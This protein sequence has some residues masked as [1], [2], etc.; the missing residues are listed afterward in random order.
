MMRACSAAL[1]DVCSVWCDVVGGRGVQTT[2]GAS[3][4]AMHPPQF[5]HTDTIPSRPLLLNSRTDAPGFMDF[6]QLGRFWWSVFRLVTLDS[7]PTSTLALNMLKAARL[8]PAAA[9]SFL[10]SSRRLV[11]LHVP[12]LR[13]KRRG[14]L[15]NPMPTSASSLSHRMSTTGRPL[16]F[17][18]CSCPGAPPDTS[19]NDTVESWLQKASCMPEGAHF[20]LCTHPLEGYSASSSPNGSRLPKGV[21][22]GR[23]STPLMK[24]EN[25]RALKSLL[26]VASRMLLGCQSTLRTVDLC[27]LMCLD[28]HQ[29]LSTSK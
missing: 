10:A 8:A 25:T 13:E 14:L 17:T 29:S 21:S 28:T 22:P 2:G 20:T 6:R 3:S 12:P 1:H 16:N 4:R 19:T 18:L 7:A 5:F 15:S 9:A 24:P 26:A 11:K 27:F 23:S